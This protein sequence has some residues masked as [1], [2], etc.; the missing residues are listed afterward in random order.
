MPF[1]FTV[2]EDVEAQAL[3]GRTR[4]Q[5]IAEGLRGTSEIAAAVETLFRLVSDFSINQAID[6]ALAQGR[7][8]RRLLAEPAAA[9]AAL[10]QMVRLPLGE[11]R[12]GILRR[13]VDEA[14]FTPDMQQA[15]FDY[16]PP[17]PSRTRNLRFV[18]QGTDGGVVS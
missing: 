10:P 3:I 5:V 6:A 17:D 2:I 11:T 1:D 15:L 14:V 4:E 13:A 18:D 7:K 12:D 8:L 16:L 9:K